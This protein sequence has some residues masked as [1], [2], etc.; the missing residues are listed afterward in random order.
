[1]A[2]FD[3]DAYL[4]RRPFNPNGVDRLQGLADA[5]QEK[6]KA[7]AQFGEERRVRDEANKGSWVN[8]LGLDADSAGGQAVNLAASFASGAS[9][10][11]GQFAA[12]PANLQAMADEFS[13]DAGDHEAYNRYVGGKATPEDMSRL[14]SKKAMFSPNDRPED[15]ARAQAEA[16]KNPDAL[17]VMQLFNRA[18]VSRDVG[19]G[20]AKRFNLEGIVNNESRQKMQKQLEGGFDGNWERVKKGWESLKKGE[21]AQGWGD[22]AVG[23]GKLIFNAAESAAQNPQAASEYIVENIPQLG[24]G[25]LGTAGKASLT[26]SNVGYG[27]DLYQQ[28]LAKYQKDNGGQLPSMEE[29]Q[30]MAMN[31]A[32]A[33]LAEQA[34]DMLSLDFM[35]AAGKAG[36]EVTRT[37]LKQAL[38]NSLKATAEGGVTEG[39][40]EGAQTYMEG[41]ATGKPASAKDIYVGTTVGAIAGSGMSG[42]G[43]AVAEMAQATPEHFQRRVNAAQ[44]QQDHLAA[45]ASN[46]TSAYL[47]PKNPSHDPVKAAQVLFGHAQL[48][49]TSEET[50]Q[51]N[52]AQANKIVSDLEERR[53]T[54]QASLDAVSPERLTEAQD[55][56]QRAKDQG[57]DVDTIKALEADVLDI[58]EGQKNTKRIQARLESLDSQLGDVRNVKDGLNALI[59]PKPED[60]DNHVAQANAAVTSQSPEAVAQAK[61]AA[62][63]VINLSMAHPNA[64]SF[65]AASELANNMDNGLSQGQRTYLRAFSEARQAENR[66]K[67]MGSVG[68]EIRQGDPAKNQLGIA[69]YRSRVA[70]ALQ[71]GNQAEADRNLVM[72]AKFTDDHTAKARIV[73]YALKQAVATGKGIQVVR[74]KAGWA[75][76]DQAYTNDEL[77]ANGGLTIHKGSSGLV[78]N[79]LSGAKALRQSQAEL[80]AAYDLRFAPD[81]QQAQ[82]S[83]NT[84]ENSVDSSTTQSTQSTAVDAVDSN[85]SNVDVNVNK[86]EPSTTAG[87]PSVEDQ[88]NES[89]SAPSQE[90]V[91]ED[92][93]QAVD[94][95]ADAE[96]GDLQSTEPT[97]DNSQQTEDGKLSNFGKESAVDQPYN[98]QD[99]IRE[100]F[101]QSAGSDTG[102]QRPLAKVKNFLSQLAKGVVSAKDFLLKP[103]SAEGE[104]QVAVLSK[105]KEE[106]ARWF[107]MI[108]RNL[109]AGNKRKDDSKFYFKDLM[110]FLIQKEDGKLSLEENVKTA[111]SVAGFSWVA[112]NATRSVANSDEAINMILGRDEG[113][114][115]SER[116]RDVLAY[117]GSWEGVVINSLGQ[118]AVQALGLKPTPDA[119]KDLLPRLESAMGAHVLKLL[120]D[121]GILSRQIVSGKA[122]KALTGND[123]TK[124]NAQF[125][126]IS[127]A[128][129]A[130]RNLSPKA[131]AIYQANKGSQGF[132]DKLFSVESSAKEPSF[133]PIPFNQKTTRNTS[134][135]VPE[136]LAKIVEAKNAEANYVRQDMWHLMSQLDESAALVIAGVASVSETDTH[137]SKRASI[138][139]KN[140]GLIREFRNFM[141]FVG[142]TVFPSEKGLEQPLYFE[143]SVWKQQR[144]GI[145]TNVLNPQSSKIHR[146]MLFRKAWETSV[147]MNDLDNFKLRVMEGLGVKTDKQGNEK[148]LAGFDAKVGA[149]EI[150]AAVA[151]LQKTLQGDALS[152]A[153]QEIL[154][155]GVKAGG[156]KFHSLDALMALA[157]YEQAKATGKDSF[158]VQM[159]G[160]VD[161]VTNGP[162]LSHLLMGAA[163]SVKELFGLLNRGG[164]FQEGNE[165]TQYNIWRGQAGH[166]DLYEITTRH[167]LDNVRQLVKAKGKDAVDQRLLGAV[168][169]FTGKLENEETGA[170]EKAGR[171]I[172]KTP[173]T[174]MVFG[175]SVSSALDS[176]ADK[177]VE[178]IYD[179][180]ES[181][182][183]D[184]AKQ[185]EVILNLRTLGVSIK[186]GESLMERE[187]DE[188]EIAR[189]KDAFKQTLGKAV[190]AT[191]KQDFSTFIE[192]R[193]ILNET[194]G[195]SFAVYDAAYRGFRTQFIE[196]MVQRTKDGR[197]DGIPING[198]GQPIRDLTQAEE[199]ALRQKVARLMPVLQ[200]LMAKDSNNQKAGLLV[201]KS[202]RKLSDESMYEGEIQFG[203]AF[204]DNKAFSVTTHGYTTMAAAPGVAMAPMSIHSTDS[205]ISHYAAEG[206]E[207]LN[208]HDAHGSGLGQFAQTARNLN[209]ATWNAMLNYSP[210]GEMSA[211]LVRTLQGL[212]QLLQ[213]GAPDVV[214]QNIANELLKMA[215]KKELPATGFLTATLIESHYLA[216]QADR[217][218]LESLSQ[219]ASVDQYALEGGNYE[220]T[221]EDR[222]AAKAKL[223]ELNGTISPELMAMVDRIESSL[224]SLLRVSGTKPAVTEATEPDMVADLSSAQAMQLLDHGSKDVSLPDTV[225]QQMDQ[226]LTAMLTGAQGFKAA[227][228]KTLNTLDA[229]KLSQLLSQRLALIPNTLWGGQGK[230]AIESDAELV[231]LFEK[232]PVLTAQQAVRVLAKKISEGKKTNVQEFN[233]RLL[234]LIE[235]T[236]NPEL[237]I[238]YVTPATV[239]AQVLS[240]PADASRGWYV[241]QN[242]QEAIY[243][244]SPD[245]KFSGL[246]AETL[247]HE[248]THGALAKVIEQ[249]LAAKKADPKYTSPALE[250]VNELESLRAKAE[251]FM[252]QNNLGEFKAAVTNVHE[253]VSWGMSNLDFQKKVLNQ[254]SMPSKT[255][256]NTLVTGMK[257]FISAL[258]GLLFR[259]SNKT[260]QQQAENGLSVLIGNVSGL[261]Y[262]AAQ[263]NKPATQDINLSMAAQIRDMTT[264]DLFDALSGNGSAFTEKMRGLLDGVVSKLHGPFGSLKADLMSQ[265]VLSPTD[266]WM[267]ALAANEA[268]F[269][270]DALASGFR[271]TDQEAFVL[272]QVEATVRAALDGD[273]SQTTFAYSELAKLYQEVRAK[274][275]A[276]DFV[277]AGIALNLQQAEKLHDFIFKMEKSVGDRSDYLARFAAVG[278][279][280]EGF[281]KVLDMATERTTPGNQAKG[282]VARLDAFFHKVLAWMVA[283]VTHT[284]EGQQANDKL[285]HLVD[286]LVGIEAKKRAHL[287]SRESNLLEPLETKG[288][289]AVEYVRAKVGEFGRSAVFKQTKNGFVNATGAVLSTIAQDRM[290]Y[291]ME[292]FNRLRDRHFRKRQGVVAGLINEIR[293]ANDSNKVFHVLLRESKK[294]EGERK[295]EINAAAQLVLES[296]ANQGKDLTEAQKKAISYVF[297]RADLVTLLDQHGLSGIQQFLNSPSSLQREIRKLESQLAAYPQFQH[298]FATQA[299]VTAFHMV[300]NKA[301]GTHLM[302]NA[303]NIARLHD[304]PYSGRMSEQEAQA[305]EAVLDQLISLRALEYTEQHHKEEAKDL[306]NKEMNRADG[307]GVEMVLKLHKELQTQ[308]RERLFEGGQTLMTKGYT[309]EIYN[310]YREVK[311]ANLA[312]GAKLEKMG[313]VRVPGGKVSLD[314][315]ERNQG[316][317]QHLYL[318][319]DGGLRAHTT[320]T[321]SYTGMRA[322]GSRARTDGVQ[323]VDEWSANQ[324]DLKAM[325]R[326]KQSAVGRL[327][328]ANPGFDPRQVKENYAVPVLN[329][330]G[331]AVSYRYLMQA[332]TKD[333]LLERDNRFDRILGTLAGSIYDKETSADQNRKVVEALHQQYQQEFATRSESYVRIGPDST[334]AEYREIWKLL[335]ESTKQAVKEIWGGEGMQVRVDL[336]DINF[337]YRKSSLS[338]AFTKEATQRN[339]AE[340]F[341]VDLLTY[342]MGEKAALRVRRAEDIWQE[343]VKETK[344]ILVV[345][346]GVTLMGNVVSNLSELTWF[347][348]SPKDILT[349]HRVALKGASDYRKNRDAL[350]ALK[351]KLG[352]DYSYGNRAEME[353]EVIR[354]EDAIARNPVRELIEAGL[355][356]SIVEDVA[357][358]DDL[359]SYKSRF[360]RGT[361][362]DAAKVNPAV[363]NVAKNVYMS[364]DTKTYQALT[365]GTQISDFVAR[366][367]LYQHLTTRKKNPM[368]K[369]AA[370]QL[371]SDAFV[372][373]DIPSHR[374]IQYL[375]DM[376]AVWFTKYYI[377]ILKVITHLYRIQ[378]GRA[379]AIL[380]LGEY[381][382]SLPVLT[383]SHLIH[384]M[385]NPFSMGALK[386]PG[387]LD[388]LATVKMG[389]SLF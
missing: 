330:Q 240:G 382:D 305:A 160:E 87:K 337:G 164:F 236:V 214:K 386:Y 334:D 211:V 139:A 15:I 77:R 19:Q 162:M 157:H 65:E 215:G 323:N 338:D 80:R 105:F 41:E 145:A 21:D 202:D 138:Q 219:M 309:P 241:N 359:Y 4:R 110:Q 127:L 217:I 230:P 270:S 161:G 242:N 140:D 249:E 206:N 76:A 381:F 6:V 294:H 272:E 225:R 147:S 350:D 120:L 115:V 235:K 239:A 83:G 197:E 121:D 97:A 365:Y 93:T 247:L 188:G 53:A 312:E 190:E 366:Y 356:P 265:T 274:V 352:A 5:A 204:G 125:K 106:V 146:F 326:A 252:G 42:G 7:L 339:I 379:L 333:A 340:K 280:H 131:D 58:K 341:F 156:E 169:A 346:S 361:E 360:V 39:M 228:S 231:A 321:L 102:A 99:L 124:E 271:F 1:M 302:L 268:P 258:T 223:A 358:E 364:K 179:Q 133:E 51:A 232:R 107:P 66:L 85:Q 310:P 345:K 243:V 132:L 187:F 181:A 285:T 158:T 375:N 343:I 233:L 100:Y 284:F 46:D 328:A 118:R 216:E 314:P 316:E 210:A 324:D 191:M 186:S 297:L 30:H 114:L 55:D 52:L 277:N 369:A 289:E 279:A 291:L 49:S 296:F 180:M 354:L 311:V 98:Q 148:S 8:R 130:Q 264:L 282:F 201:A 245:F 205:A 60:I 335:P 137:K 75:V 3:M 29:R 256:G 94:S 255:Q 300:S 212:D 166:L 387:A 168:Y 11:G 10:V 70:E 283:K 260:S 63:T 257:S 195:V 357:A 253:L 177:F 96:L 317:E 307:N 74:T 261:F 325:H 84:Q 112:E 363:L 281:N 37:G 135:Q 71:G 320:G 322:K 355:M 108:E 380:A 18:G 167:V 90:A 153:D 192:S 122:M 347:G 184:P 207:V 384:R 54:V 199:R 218:K 342:I 151:V 189:L 16:D 20:V 374:T 203:Q 171:N 262:Q 172:I 64:L 144:V 259:S 13:L 353:R 372:N 91:G 12:L 174:A 273:G 250:L 303:G 349:H 31:A 238:R 176:M 62:D 315:S 2:D 276:Q 142:S 229:A 182:A 319:R 128:R 35:K 373:Y 331:E 82:S 178:S 78:G 367:T 28:G 9:R 313:Y 81:N 193:K 288:K 244:L 332:E 298:Y 227:V 389:M 73:A 267:Q 292:G 26:A 348:V 200:T 152:A 92:S 290:D 213:S 101:A 69:Q 129:D 59:Q 109:V 113:H 248:L 251:A 263:T 224:D 163:S 308:S 269:A 209:Q 344:D 48:E 141:D 143:H 194:A 301:T 43:R 14:N 196:E 36:K 47:D 117:A 304:T 23:I 220:V 286:Q 362:K 86:I 116:E 79:I 134:Q 266:L 185:K 293:G 44:A 136:R 111:L 89:Q 351:L 17:S 378:P 208:I 123:K 126:F 198:K 221:A 45:I 383:D 25:L 104:R 154:I 149:S 287:L 33:V 299:K 88:T 318:L 173:L 119:P 246:T 254:L 370:V 306:L 327:F 72:L 155:K 175:S 56:L 103:E 237:T 371:A 159:V 57:R 388:D 170:V 22:M 226:V 27:A 95:T 38:K 165:N 336:L 150:K 34:G 68:A 24:L 295:N 278:L 40:T 368:D 50:K 275:S 61:Q 32:G 385:N 67:S 329:A 234:K 377:R 222:A 376:G 183:K